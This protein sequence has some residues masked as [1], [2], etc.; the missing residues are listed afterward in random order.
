MVVVAGLVNFDTLG[1][2]DPFKTVRAE[3]AETDGEGGGKGTA[4]EEG[5][6]HGFFFIK[7][8][9]NILRK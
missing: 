8:A 5:F 2:D 7:E 3:S 1:S 6:V 4:E 9:I